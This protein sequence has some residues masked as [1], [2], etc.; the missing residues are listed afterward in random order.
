MSFRSLVYLAVCLAFPIQAHAQATDDAERKPPLQELMKTELPFA[1]ERGEIQVTVA[2]AFG[3]SIGR[4]SLDLP[5][6]IEYGLTDWWQVSAEWDAFRRLRSGAVAGRGTGGA[7][8]GTMAGFTNPGG[9]PVHVAAGAEMSFGR[10]L[11]PLEEG[12]RELEPFA[13]AAFDLGRSGVQIFGQ[14]GVGVTLDREDDEEPADR[15]VFWGAGALLPLRSLTLA[16]EFNMEHESERRAYLTPS[17]T[18]RLNRAWEVAAGIPI[19]LT[20]HAETIGL[21]VHVIYE[22]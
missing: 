1:Q 4:I 20:R 19:G 2:S 9:W 12:E 5:L 16:A 8:I 13:A 10:R 3:R 7:A 18:V 22:R 6:S 21:N 11:D 17:L 15:E 14:A